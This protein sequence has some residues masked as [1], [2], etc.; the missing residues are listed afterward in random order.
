M[1][2]QQTMGDKVRRILKKVARKYVIRDD[3]FIQ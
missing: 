1:S 3:K 2:L